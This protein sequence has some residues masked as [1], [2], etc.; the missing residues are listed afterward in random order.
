MK[1]LSGQKITILLLSIVTAASMGVTVWAVFFRSVP[2]SR[3]YA[4]VETEP[5]AVSYQ[6]EEETPQVG[7]GGGAVSIRYTK[8]VCVDTAAQTAQ[9][10]YA[11]P[12]ESASSV[13]LQLVLL[14]DSGKETVLGESG[15]LQPGQSWK[16]CGF[17]RWSVRREN[18][19]ES[20]C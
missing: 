7:S 20:L 17:Q 6:E 11:N 16:S 9:I 15:L 12:P 10:Y 1:K 18:I 2:A 3:D 13:T 19:R 14:D 5:N 4:L 8:Q